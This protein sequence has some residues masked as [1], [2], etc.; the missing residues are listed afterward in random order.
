[1]STQRFVINRSPIWRPLL[2]LFSGVESKSYV[3]IEEG[4]IRARFGWLFDERFSMEDVVD[5]RRRRWPLLFGLGWR[6]DFRGHVGLTGSFDSI[7]QV[8][9]RTKRTV[10]LGVLAT[11]CDRVSVSLREP[12]LFVDALQ[13]ARGGLATGA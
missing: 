6:T 8:R 13:E 12:D 11:P 9:F 10:R 5:V 2:A 4:Q 1:M 7:V 3:E